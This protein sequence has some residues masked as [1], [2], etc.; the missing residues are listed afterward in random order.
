MGLAPLCLSRYD[1]TVQ[2]ITIECEPDL[3]EIAKQ[4]LSKEKNQSL[5][6]QTGAYHELLPDSI[7]QLQQIDCVFVGKDVGVNDWDTVFEQCY[8]FVHDSAFFVLAGIR[9]STEKQ[10]YWMQ[11][12]QH[13][14]VTVVIDLYDLGLL[15]F[16][17]KIQKMVYKTIFS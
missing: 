4:I 12:R 5:S 8:P 15:F 13:P 7:V 11:F 10:S 17:P 1:S 3:A 9:S 16:Q 6:I 2:C 14:S